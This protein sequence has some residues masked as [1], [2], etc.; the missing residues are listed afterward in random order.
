VAK[1]KSG[2][3]EQR[4]KEVQQQK[5][6][7]YIM[8]GVAIGVLVL[9]LSALWFI[10]ISGQDI[11]GVFSFGTQER[12]HDE[13]IV[14]EAANLPPVGGVHSPRWQT[15][16]IYEQPVD[17]KNAVHSMEHGAVWIAYNPDLPATEVQSLQDLVRGQSYLLLSPYPDLSSNIVLTAWGIQ[18]E[19]D[20]VGD[21]RVAQ[22]INQY[23]LGPQTPEFGATCDGG[24]GTPVG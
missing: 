23:R 4:R 2:R 15:C 24:V 17:T 22:F 11:E 1:R 7:R 3:K 10:R 21:E 16:G 8:I 12:G 6:R 14:Y 19:A 20:S 9:A 5:R 13:S 18:L